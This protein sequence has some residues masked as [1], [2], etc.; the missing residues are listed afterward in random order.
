[1]D[2]L[3]NKKRADGPSFSLQ[4]RLKRLL[5]NLIYTIFFRYTPTQ[6]YIWRVF[7]LRMFGADI[8][9]NCHVYPKV[10][11]WAPWNLKMGNNS[12]LANNV[13]CYSQA[14]IT[15]DDGAIVSQ[16]SHLCAG[17]HDYNDPD[18]Q[19]I[20]APIFIGQN[21]WIAAEAFVGPG[22]TIG[23]GAVLGARGVTF[24]D[25]EPWT[26]NAGNPS[27]FIKNRVIN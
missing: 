8:G 19:L 17:S 23:D 16:G 11:I 3:K 10:I 5:W 13:I 15:I 7:I 6:L 22:V 27:K 25:I 14:L 18:F 9:E 21:A 1:M 4:N 24:K 26:V 20:V 12:C 2:V